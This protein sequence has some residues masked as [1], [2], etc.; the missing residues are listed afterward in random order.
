MPIQDYKIGMKGHEITY[1]LKLSGHTVTQIAKS[2]G[3]S[4]PTV[5]QVIYGVRTTARIRQAIAI[6]VG[7]PV[8][9]LWPEQQ[10][11]AKEAA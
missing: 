5:T 2:L 10:S 7:K 9:E 6:A 3:V 1:F 11:T 4:Q 8:S